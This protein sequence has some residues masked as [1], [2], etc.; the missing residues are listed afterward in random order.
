MQIT[1]EITNLGSIRACG[2]QIFLEMMWRNDLK[3]AYR[4]IKLSV[5]LSMKS[6]QS[7]LLLNDTVKELIGIHSMRF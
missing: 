2:S 6:L 7:K 3:H 5:I 1:G 4:S